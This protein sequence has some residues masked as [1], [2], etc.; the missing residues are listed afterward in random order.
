MRPGGKLVVMR[1]CR[2][3]H[4]AVVV[5][6]LLCGRVFADAAPATLPR[7]VSVS[8]FGAVADGKTLSTAAFQKALN[9]IAERGGGEVIVPA[10]NYLIGS[11]F[12]GPRTT[13]RIEKDATIIGSPNK[14]D[15][16]LETV[17]WEGRWRLG[18]RA[19]L[20]ANKSDHIAIVGEGTIVGDTKLAYLRDPRGPCLI[21]PVQCRDVRIE[22]IS[23]RYERMWTIHL[24][25]C[26]D[27]T[28]RNLHIRTTPR[29]S[30]GDGIDVDS[31]RRVTIEGCDIDA[32]DDAIA[33]KSGRGMEAV[34]IAKPTEDVL[35]RNCKLGSTFAGI[36]LGTE[37][38]GGLRNIR[39]ENCQF[40]RG[41]NAIYIKSRT[42]RGGFIENVEFRNVTSNG[43]RHF[44]HI[45]LITKGIVDSRTVEGIDGIPHVRNI[46]V[47]GATV[48][49]RHLLLAERI[50]PEKPLEGL[51]FRNIRG[52]CEQGIVLSNM[53]DVKLADINVTGHTGPLIKASNVPGVET[54]ATQPATNNSR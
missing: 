6:L 10:G 32:G 16:P 52:T 31:C 9:A 36:A 7:S 20:S 44:L 42:G 11:V 21:E 3:L 45:D 29:P 19:L 49:C 23:L 5:G 17:R 54:S 15:Y 28:V 24:T 41:V 8:D 39:V 50:A 53:R 2:I 26:E 51:T 4:F 46:A 47:D 37:M 34:T 13:L 30:N 38:S 27:V 48:D 25:Y 33:L 12:I 1:Y 22:G 35:I 43:P 14:E 40:T 18:H